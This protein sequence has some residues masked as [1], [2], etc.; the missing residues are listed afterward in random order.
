[1]FITAYSNHLQRMLLFCPNKDSVNFK[2]FTFS[3]W[4][5]SLHFINLSKAFSVTI[6]LL[7]FNNNSKIAFC[8]NTV[9]SAAINEFFT[10]A[11]LSF[12][13]IIYHLLS[14]FW[15]ANCFAISARIAG[16]FSATNRACNKTN[17]SFKGISFIPTTAS[18][19][20]II[21]LAFTAWAKSSAFDFLKSIFFITLFS[22][23]NKVNSTSAPVVLGITMV[24]LAL[25]IT[26]MVLRSTLPFL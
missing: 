20:S 23:S 1:M 5:M 22:S 4:S 14:D 3:F 8:S 26:Q 24:W 9:V 19:R 13:T 7:S 11:L 2:Y 15:L 10:S 12:T 21:C 6:L 16:C 18:Y 25:S 17:F